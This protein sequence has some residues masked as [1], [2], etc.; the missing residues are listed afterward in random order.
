MT[1][2]P[3]EI[4]SSGQSTGRFRLADVARHLG[5]TKQSVHQLAAERGFPMSA[6]GGDGLRWWDRTAIEHWADREWWG[7]KPW[8]TTPVREGT[9]ASFRAST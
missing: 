1:T 4:D 2:P 9:L 7:S 5:V 3:D 8:R 6:A